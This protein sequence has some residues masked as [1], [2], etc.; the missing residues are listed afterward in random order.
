MPNK[1]T[2]SVVSNPLS[3]KYGVLQIQQSNQAEKNQIDSFASAFVFQLVNQ[4]VKVNVPQHV[5]VTVE[6]HVLQH[7]NQ[8]VGLNANHYVMVQEVMQIPN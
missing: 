3:S 8:L 1:K 7:V 2:N 5:Q 6:K 4:T